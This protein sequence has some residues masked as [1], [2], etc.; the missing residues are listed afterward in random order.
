MASSGTYFVEMPY[1]LGS[2]L[3]SSTQNTKIVRLTM[4]DTSPVIVKTGLLN[5]AIA[6]SMSG[7]TADNAS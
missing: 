4:I 6:A 7:F 5:A 3:P 1:L 2:G